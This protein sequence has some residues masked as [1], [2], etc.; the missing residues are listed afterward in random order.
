MSYPKHKRST[1]CYRYEPWHWRYV[2]R[3]VAA[4]VRASGRTLREYLW[5]EHHQ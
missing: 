2:G 3:D 1:T 4:H 5:Y